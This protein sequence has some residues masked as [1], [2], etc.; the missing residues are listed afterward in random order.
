MH[1][2]LLTGLRQISI[3]KSLGC[4]IINPEE[5]IMGAEDGASGR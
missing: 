5:E 1:L 4:C 3:V 2:L